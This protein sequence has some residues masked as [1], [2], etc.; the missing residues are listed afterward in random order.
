MFAQRVRCVLAQLAAICLPLT[1][2]V[3]TSANVVL[4]GIATPYTQNFDNLA[5]SGN[6]NTWTNNQAATD[7]HGMNGWY[8]QES[9][10][11]SL[12]YDV[13]TGTSTSGTAY[14]F[15]VAG[16][17]PVT[18]RAMGNLG[19]AGHPNTAW[20]V[21]FQNN[22]GQALNSIT[23][24]YTGEEWRRAPSEGGL[25]FSYL[26]SSSDITTLTPGGGAVPST[27][28]W[29]GL[30]ALNFS[31][32]VVGS[33]A[34]LDGNA[35][36]NRTAISATIFATIPAGEYFA[37]RWYDGDSTNNDGGVAIDDLTLTVTVPEPSPFWF[38]CAIC[39]SV[40][41]ATSGRRLWGKVKSAA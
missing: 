27:P 26:T 10:A 20:G 11:T 16:T 6:N 35:A 36:A 1:L 5:S 37:L 17:N 19:T 31:P 13:S 14:S 18:D 4:T 24:S 41:I 21:V 30:A 28:A 40:A 12:I 38:G 39:G 8:W 29:T 2:A 22:T 34:A 25:T 15:G 33:G 9:E 23:V 32:P 7:I 3:P